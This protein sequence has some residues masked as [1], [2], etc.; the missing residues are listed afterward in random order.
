[1]AFQS[2]PDCASAAIQ[3]ARGAHTHI[4]R[5]VFAF[6]G[7][8]EQSSIDDLAEALDLAVH[9]HWKALIGAH[10]TYTSVHVRGLAD[11]ID[12]ESINADHTGVCTISGGAMPANVTFAIKFTTGAIGR[13]ARGRMYIIGAVT[14]QLSGD[15]NA[16]SSTAIADWLAAI[17]ATRVAA[18]VVG[19]QHG[20]LSRFHDGAARALAVH[21][22]V[23]GYSNTNVVMDSQ[24]GRLP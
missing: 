21:R 5:L 2:A 22:A 16:Y 7:G 12:L 9:D 15:T 20:V 6:P 10:M 19:W 14:S 4:N 1:M 8:Y 11:P 18:S 17:E 3:F 24:R 13:S 23:T